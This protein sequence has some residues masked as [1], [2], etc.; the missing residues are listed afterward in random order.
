MTKDEILNNIV[1]LSAEQ[2]SQQIEKDTITLSDLM[3]TG[4]LDSVKRRKIKEIQDA[5]EILDDQA[6]EKAEFGLESD[7]LKYINNFPNGKHKE[8]A[9]GLVQDMRK[10]SMQRARQKERV[11]S[12]IAENTNSLR[13][14]EV[15]EYLENGTIT[16]E[17]LIDVGVPSGVINLLNKTSVHFELGETPDK[18]PP[19]YTEVY[20]W[21]VPG[22]GKTCA[23]SAILSKAEKEGN[24]EIATGPGYDY[25]FQLKNIFSDDYAVL[26]NP[27]PFEKTQYLPFALRESS[28]RARSISLIELSGEIFECFYSE[29]ASKRQK[30]ELHQDTFDT[31]LDYLKSDNRKLHFFFI[32]YQKGNKVDSSGLKQSDYLDA[33]AT[34]FKN[35]KIFSKTTD[36]IYVVLTKSDLMGLPREEWVKG[37]KEHLQSHNFTSFTNTL[38]TICQQ[39]SINGK[40]L[41]VEPFS[42]GEVHF[43]KFCASDDTTAGKILD[44]LNNRVPAQGK[45]IT[46]IFNR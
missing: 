38:K 25:M 21:G 20:F 9:K 22:S 19:G 33:A 45:S 7:L 13:Q 43:N 12:R 35:N 32:D 46:D 24:L 31:L 28:K 34:Y 4:N 8:V 42:I 10:Q 40:R 6:W 23:L 29:N 39:N 3:R 16:P 17:D 37:A 5:R 15:N 26:P 1:D 14:R 11:L 44:I 2:L 27:T 18:I 41:F 30:S 36:A